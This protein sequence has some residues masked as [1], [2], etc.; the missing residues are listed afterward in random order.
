MAD[1][2][3]LDYD[4]CSRDCRIRGSHTLAW[5]SCEHATEPEPT[6]AF[7]RHF[8]ASDGKPA[9]GTVT[10][11][12]SRLADELED[13]LRSHGGTDPATVAAALAAHLAQKANNR[14]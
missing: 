2:T 12:V 1:P 6:V 4:G 14:G 9:L 13:V 8:T 11:T 10:F 7:L 5:G 3:P